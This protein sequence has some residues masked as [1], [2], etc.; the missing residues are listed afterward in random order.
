[1]KYV[2][3]AEKPLEVDTRELNFPQLY[4][5]SGNLIDNP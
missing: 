2:D 4:D 1:M 5:H 3:G